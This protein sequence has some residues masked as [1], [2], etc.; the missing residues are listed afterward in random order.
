MSGPSARGCDDLLRL[1]LGDVVPAAGRVHRWRS[2]VLAQQSS[3]GHSSAWGHAQACTWPNDPQVF[4][5]A[6]LYRDRFRAGG[7]SNVPITPSAGQS[8][9]IS[10]RE[11]RLCFA[12]PCRARV[13]LRSHGTQVQAAQCAQQALRRS[14]K[15]ALVQGTAANSPVLPSPT[16]AQPPTH[17]MACSVQPARPAGAAAASSGVSLPVAIK[18]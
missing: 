8:S 15:F 6:P 5:D 12:A 9:G 13:R 3:V 14:C 11:R 17:C 4:R 10:T 2:S 7:I 18:G 1:V 16:P